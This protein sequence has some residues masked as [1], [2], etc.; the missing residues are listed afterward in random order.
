MVQ[1]AAIHNR[2][3]QV[4]TQQRSGNIFK[5]PSS[6]SQR[7]NR[8]SYAG[9]NM[10]SQQCW[11]ERH[12]QSSGWRSS[13]LARLGPLAWPAPYHAYNAIADRHVSAPLGLFR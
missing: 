10:D 11:P 12:G 8:Q 3:V 7:K 1:A 4:G 5:R 13:L 6:R 9:R 2:I